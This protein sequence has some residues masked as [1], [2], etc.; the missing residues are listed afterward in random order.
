VPLSL[1]RRTRGLDEPVGIAISSPGSALGRVLQ[2]QQKTLSW[3][4]RLNQSGVPGCFEIIE[5]SCPDELR[6]WPR[7]RFKSDS[8][9]S[10]SEEITHEIGSDSSEFKISFSLSTIVRS[11]Q[12]HRISLRQSDSDVTII[13]LSTTFVMLG[14]GSVGLCSSMRRREMQSKILHCIFNARPS[15]PYWGLL[16]FDAG[17]LRHISILFEILGMETSLTH[18]GKAPDNPTRSSS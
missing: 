14:I 17:N 5:A 3:Y 12:R 18:E 1:S 2:P 9:Q 6:R 15:K 10:P 13:Q 8:I 7:L 11:Y 16:R 4:I